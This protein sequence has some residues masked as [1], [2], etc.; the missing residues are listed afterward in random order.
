M[1]ERVR[2]LAIDHFSS[3]DR[4][5]LIAA[6]G[7]RFAWRTVPYWVFRNAANA[8]FPK[9]VREGLENWARPEFGERRS[10]FAAWCRHELSRLYLEWPFDVLLLPSDSLYYVRAIPDACHELGIPVMVAQKETTI[11][12]YSMAEHAPQ[13]RT[14]APF[15][16]D[17]MTVCSERH[18]EFWVR[19]GTDPAAIEVTGQPRFDVYARPRPRSARE[20]RMVLFLSYEPD[21]YLL[22]DADRAIGWLDLRDETERILYNS[23]AAG[24]DVVVKLHPLQ[25]REQ[26]AAA[27]EIKTANNPH[28]RLA[29]EG[30][31]TRELILDAD[32]V[33]GFQTTA[34]YE[35]MAAGKP[36]AYTAWGAAYDRFAPLLIPF[37]R[38][39]DLL[40][41]VRSGEELASWLRD[42]PPVDE[43]Q[44]SR[45]LAYV[46]EMLGPFDGHAS[47]RTL[48]AIRRQATTWAD[49]A[50]HSS[51]RK[52]LNRVRVLARPALLG[53]AAAQSAGLRLAVRL[54]GRL[55][56]S[57]SYRAPR[58]EERLEALRRR[59]RS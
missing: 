51:R 37:D 59:G 39:D 4:N 46:E 50:G 30:S 42:P 41:V 34:L 58:Y 45:R 40:R 8:L 24:W 38:R 1:A 44:Q 5:A 53:A 12:D 57:A 7:E 17:H 21:A 31:D 33:V 26:E 9:E 43:G 22:D 52:M 23:T 19:A 49:R 16:S 11:T 48:D 20:R 32:A 14:F 54:P 2:V 3:Q 25:H 47:A 27:F 29:P 6:G 35:A 13:V 55:G 10:R 36:I 56:S 18:K 15:V 28:A